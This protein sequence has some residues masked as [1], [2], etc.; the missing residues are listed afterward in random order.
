MVEHGLRGV[1]VPYARNSRSEFYLVNFAQGM[2]WEEI[3]K[4]ARVLMVRMGH[5]APPVYARI[6]L[7]LIQARHYYQEETDPKRGSS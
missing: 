2:T 1:R 5:I 3:N 4:Y 7:H 6:S